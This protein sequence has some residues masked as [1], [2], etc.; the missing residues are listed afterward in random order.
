VTLSRSV[1]LH[2][3]IGRDQRGKFV[4]AESIE[5]RLSRGSSAH[6][7]ALVAAIEVVVLDEA[8]EV[9]LDLFGLGVPGLATLHLEA[10][11]EKNPVRELD[12][13]VRPGRSRLGLTVLD[14]FDSQQQLV[15]MA[16]LQTAVLAP[17][18]HQ[19]SANQGSV[20][21]YKIGK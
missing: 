16:L 2:H 7:V 6:A 15:G 20:S 1:L 9:A 10:L 18:V 12:K 5:E 17:V 21:E 3:L 19:Y 4:S 8:V 14:I 13:A 11:L